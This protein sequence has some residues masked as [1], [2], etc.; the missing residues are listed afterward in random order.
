[1]VVHVLSLM[2]WFQTVNDN[3]VLKLTDHNPQSLQQVMIV[4][5]QR[6]FAN[7]VCKVTLKHCTRVILMIQK[8]LLHQRR[9]L[10]AL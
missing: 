6:R 4:L 10:T 1:M 5:H 3:Y 9:P 7:H 8:Q 2:S